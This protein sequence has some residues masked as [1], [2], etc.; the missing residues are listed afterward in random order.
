MIFVYE[1]F[2]TLR[3]CDATASSVLIKSVIAIF[4]KSP[5][6]SQICT[7]SKHNEQIEIFSLAG[8]QTPYFSFECFHFPLLLHRG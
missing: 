4:G 8:I 3:L 1:P 2:V 6:V 7:K 5:L